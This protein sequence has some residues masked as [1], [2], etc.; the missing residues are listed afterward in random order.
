MTIDQLSKRRAN[1]SADYAGNSEGRGARP[2]DIAGAPVAEQVGKC[3]GGN[4]KGAGA[5]GDM[6]IADGDNLEQERY[7]QNRTTAAD[8]SKREP[9]RPA[10]KHCQCIL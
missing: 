9:Y 6:C 10:E 5:D 3:I 7:C 1:R 8:Q 4:G 2:F